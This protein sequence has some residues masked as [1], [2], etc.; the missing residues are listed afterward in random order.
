MAYRL[1]FMAF[2]VGTMAA[3]STAGAHE[4]KVFA[5]RPMLPEGGGKSTIFLCEGH[6]VPVD[7]LLEARTIDRYDLVSPA[8]MKSTLKTSGLSIQA[9]VVELREAG[10]HTVV[11]SRKPGVWTYILDGRGERRLMRGSKRD[12]A[13]EPIETSTHYSEFAKTLVVV[14]KPGEVAPK[15]AGLAVEIVPLDGPARWLAHRD[16]RFQVLQDGKAVP[17]VPVVARQVGF[18]PDDAWSYAT[19]T[20]KKGEFSIRPD[21]AGTWI[22]GIEYRT[23]MRDDRRDEYDFASFATTLTFEVLP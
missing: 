15:A 14:G 19:E 6:R 13:G 22:V 17:I 9:N 16:I 23:L 3:T 5:S 2:V 1:H 4:L 18:K 12:H 21:R 10:V 11:A 7:E 8:G 20:S